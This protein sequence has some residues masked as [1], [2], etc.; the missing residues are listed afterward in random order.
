[1]MRA[2]CKVATLVALVLQSEGAAA[3]SG[4]LGNLLDVPVDYCVGTRSGNE[5]QWTQHRIGPCEVDQWSW[6]LAE[7]ET[8]LGLVWPVWTDSR[9]GDDGRVITTGNQIAMNTEGTAM[10]A[11]F[12]YGDQIWLDSSGNAA[13]AMASCAEKSG[14]PAASDAAA[15]VVD[16]SARPV[17][18]DAVSPDSLASDLVALVRLVERGE[19]LLVE[20][21]GTPDVRGRVVPVSAHELTVLLQL[22]VLAGEMQLHEVGEMI[23]LTARHSRTLLR[24]V[25][26]QMEAGALK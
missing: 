13:A 9:K 3:E 22:E 17:A 1:M 25:I 12:R 8:G 18:G 15:A 2:C 24:D 19:I 21:G 20:I 11:F 7:G 5:V 14:A 26:A 4:R 6:T 23:E 10:V 16:E